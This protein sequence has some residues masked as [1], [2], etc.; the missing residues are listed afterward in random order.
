MRI[1]RIGKIGNA[2]ITSN[3]DFGSFFPSTFVLA[4][5]CFVKGTLPKG[6]KTG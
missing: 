5:F 4:L 6:A 2:K 3:G 1:N